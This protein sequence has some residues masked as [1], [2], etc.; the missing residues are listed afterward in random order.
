MHSVHHL[1][2][3]A[4]AC[5]TLKEM[6]RAVLEATVSWRLCQLQ[7]VI[8]GKREKVIEFSKRLQGLVGEL[9]VRDTRYLR[10][11]KSG[12]CYEDFPKTSCHCRNS[13]EQKL[14]VSRRSCK[15]NC[16]TD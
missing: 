11:S 16:E 10:Y 12:L 6:F 8:L 4:E 5:M 2:G 3:P 7:A 1:R 13:I 9:I 15:A 14:F